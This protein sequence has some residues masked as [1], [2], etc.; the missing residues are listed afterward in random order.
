MKYYKVPLRS[1]SLP[2]TYSFVCTCE[3]ANMSKLQ[4]N[5]FSDAYLPRLINVYINSKS[6]FSVRYIMKVDMHLKRAR[7]L[8]TGLL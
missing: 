5:Y 1:Q 3:T 6:F 7:R 8:L 4:K 2:E